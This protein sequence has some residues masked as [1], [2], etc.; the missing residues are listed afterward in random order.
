MRIPYVTICMKRFTRTMSLTK[1]SIEEKLKLVKEIILKM[2]DDTV[3]LI[4]FTAE[5]EI[6]IRNNETYDKFIPLE[7]KIDYLIKKY[8]QKIKLIKK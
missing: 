7:K 5:I 1:L 3:K 8:N 4:N 2:N 6:K